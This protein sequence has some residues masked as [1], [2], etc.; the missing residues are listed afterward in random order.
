MD[1][2]ENRKEQSKEKIRQAS[3]ELINKYGSSKVTI[4]DIAHKAGVSQVTIY[5]LFSSKDKLIQGC[6]ETLFDGFIERL[7]AMIRENKPYLQRLEDFICDSLEISNS[8]P[9]FGAFVSQRNPRVK[10]SINGFIDRIM[11]LFIEL[12]KEGRNQGYLNPGLS[13][14]AIGAYFGIIMRGMPYPE[15]QIILNQDPQFFHD[16]LLIML[17]GFGRLDNTDQAGTISS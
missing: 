7:N 12:I 17:Y 6:F 13:D 3:I 10:E 1:G 16:L 2:F 8:N 11:Q 5:N 9:G 4:S 14:K 15:I